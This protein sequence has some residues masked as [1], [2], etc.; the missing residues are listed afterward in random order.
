VGSQFGEFTK[1]DAQDAYVALAWRGRDPFADVHA[2]A[3]RSMEFWRPALAA[4]SRR[5][6]SE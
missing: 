1:G 4:M 2:F 6:V 3:S 5:A